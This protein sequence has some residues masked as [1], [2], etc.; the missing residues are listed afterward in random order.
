[1]GAA[2]SV[3]GGVGVAHQRQHLRGREGVELVHGRVFG[4]TPFTPLPQFGHL[5]HAPHEALGE[6]EQ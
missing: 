3:A 6:K 2:S 5:Q 4:R 1:M